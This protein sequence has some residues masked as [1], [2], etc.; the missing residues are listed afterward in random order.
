MADLPISDMPSVSVYSNSDIVLV[1]DVSANTTKQ[2][3][4]QNF[5]GNVPAFVSVGGGLTVAGNTVVNQSI[6]L[7]GG[8]TTIGSNN[9]T[10]QFGAGKEGTIAW[11]TNYLYVAVS[12]TE[13]KRVALT[14]F[15]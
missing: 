9:A 2:D 7:G 6:T 3:S 14:V 13:I 8:L 12:N 4:L 1:V 15:S 5:F 11:D 10:T